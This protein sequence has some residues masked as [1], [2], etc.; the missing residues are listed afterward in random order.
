LFANPSVRTFNAEISHEAHNKVAAL[1]LGRQCGL[2]IPETWVSNH[3]ARMQE[4]LAVQ[5]SIAKPVAGGGYCQTLDEALESVKADFSAMPALIQSRLVAPE[6]RLFVV[7][8]DAFAFHVSSPS[9]DYRV[10]Q[11]AQ[12]EL[13]D[14]PD[15]I[16]PLRKLM[17]K[18]RMNF[19]AAD[20]KTNP[21]TG[22]LVFLELNTSPM[23]AAFDRVSHGKLAESMVK[24][25][26]TNPS[27]LNF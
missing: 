19:G 8:E 22:E 2:E 12:L 23:F 18:L 15:V 3:V 9:L 10:K 13:V 14:I 17:G 11:D 5:P 26:N 25:L 20:F 6:I 1:I 27:G 24:C 7:G 4:L 21:D 16:T